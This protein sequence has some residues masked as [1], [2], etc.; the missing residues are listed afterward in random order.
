MKM[1]KISITKSPW[2]A[3]DLHRILSEV[4][5]LRTAVKRLAR[6]EIGSVNRNASVPNKEHDLVDGSRLGLGEPV[7][8]LPPVNIRRA[9]SLSVQAD[10]RQ[11]IGG[12]QKYAVVIAYGLVICIGMTAWA[13][14]LRLALL[15][16]GRV[17]GRVRGQYPLA[18]SAV[19]PSRRPSP[20]W[21]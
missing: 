2:V 3:E 16:T 12:A 8:R 6:R 18:I 14:F 4:S 11:A 13:Y 5:E 15:R 9:T 17:D 20:S 21:S 19:G 1:H 10:V 7:Q